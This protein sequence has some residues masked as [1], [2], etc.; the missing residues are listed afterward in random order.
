MLYLLCDCLNKFVHASW[1]SFEAAF[2]VYN[3]VFGVNVFAYQRRQLTYINQNNE[4]NV[5]I[6]YATQSA[7]CSSL[8]LSHCFRSL[9]VQIR[10]GYNFQSRQMKSLKM[11]VIPF[12]VNH[13]THAKAYQVIEVASSIPKLFPSHNHV[14]KHSSV[15]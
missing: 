11:I 6:E 7:S 5:C 2:V 10:F 3:Y 13:A 14:I 1:F 8:S 9:F 4:E 12:K 15:R